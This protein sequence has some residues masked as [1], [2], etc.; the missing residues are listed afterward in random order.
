MPVKI[1]KTSS[2]YCKYFWFALVA[3]F[4]IYCAPLMAFQ[5]E[6]CVLL[7]AGFL[8]IGAYCLMEEKE[9]ERKER[10]IRM[11]NRVFFDAGLKPRH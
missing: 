11:M 8:F 9:D 2:A 6:K 4:S 7:I 5:W 1:V 10:N 3:G